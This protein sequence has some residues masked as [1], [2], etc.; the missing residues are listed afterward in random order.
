MI[1]LKLI[2]K[3][4]RMRIYNL[5]FRKDNRYNWINNK[6]SFYKKGLGWTFS[7]GGSW[8]YL[9]RGCILIIESILRGLDSQ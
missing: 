5:S 6:L 8:N 1:K 9:N 2:E 7:S 4:S 3:T